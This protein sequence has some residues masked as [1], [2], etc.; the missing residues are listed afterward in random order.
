[1]RHAFASG[2]IARGIEPVTLAKLM[3]HEDMGETLDT[4]SQLG[5]GPRRCRGARG[6][7]VLIGPSWDYEAAVMFSGRRG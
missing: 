1:M 2:M 4:Y 3:G 5:P 7:G 6:N